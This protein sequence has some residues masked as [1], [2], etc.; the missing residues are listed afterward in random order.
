MARNMES[1][2]RQ[3]E[4]SYRA[5]G[6][7]V[8]IGI[9]KAIDALDGLTAANKR[10]LD[11]F[12]EYAKKMAEFPKTVKD[13]GDQITSLEKA[14]EKEAAAAQKSTDTINATRDEQIAGLREE[15]LSEK[16]YYEAKKQIMWEAEQAEVSV[17][18]KADA[19]REK[20]KAGLEILA[21]KYGLTVKELETYFDTY[22]SGLPTLE[23]TNK[24]S[25]LLT[26]LQARL[27]TAFQETTRHSNAAGTSTKTL[28]ENLDRL[29]SALEV[30]AD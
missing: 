26:E 19:A 13:I 15:G 2:I 24:K 20:E 6:D 3:I 16:E 11:A 10:G 8:P 30:L 7:A 21:E 25:E 5:L 17:T 12:N 22:R 28:Y 14:Y 4:A 9:R 23:E 27:G 29:G 18:A 1:S